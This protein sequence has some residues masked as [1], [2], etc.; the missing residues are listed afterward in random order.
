MYDRARLQPIERDLPELLEADCKLL[1][2]RA[3]TEFKAPHQL[4]REIAPDAVAEDRDFRED[5][6]AGLEGRLLLAVLADAAVAGADPEHAAAFHE[7]VL[8]GK[9][10]EEIDAGCFYL[11]G[12]PADELVE[13]NDVVAVVPERRRG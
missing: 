11:A 4:F 2:L 8:P 6:D 13:R 9:A 7:D 3:L 5:V 10:G 12:Q 1:G